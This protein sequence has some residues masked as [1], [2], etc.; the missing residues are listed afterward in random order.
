MTAKTPDATGSGTGS[1]PAQ[2][3]TGTTP[4]V[5]TAA[6][7]GP[8]PAKVATP[9]RPAS[10]KAPA[11]RSSEGP[12]VVISVLAVLVALGATGIAIYALDQAR[13]ATTRANEA[14]SVA[15][16][17][18]APAPSR[19]TTPTTRPTTSPTPAAT[20]P[21]S[22]PAELVRQTLR[23]PAGD[24]PCASVYV[25]VDKM[26][27]GAA[28][29]HEFYITNCVGPLSVHVD[30]TAGAVTTTSNPTPEVC[31]AQITGDTASAELVL[32]VTDGLTF[33]LVTNRTDAVQ[34]SI[35][36]RI[37][38]LQITDVAADNAVTFSV[39]TYRLPAT[40]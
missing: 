9:A 21:P 14:Y 10:K 11:K 12:L 38:I 25:D 40:P 26:T 17:A 20:R 29:G 4:A 13:Q 37:A 24:S 23:V 15:G 19:A 32:P 28:A 16:R 1:V 8:A 18:A 39:S 2:P 27:V 31:A 6:A 34:Q 35:P 30:R 33:C 22:F 5:T 36:Q 7:S 3:T